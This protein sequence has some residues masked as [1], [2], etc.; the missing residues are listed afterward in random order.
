MA[1][2]RWSHKNLTRSRP[3]HTG[4]SR[5][6]PAIRRIHWTLDPH[7]T[8]KSP[9]P[10]PPPPDPIYI[11]TLAQANE[12]RNDTR[13]K[14]RASETEHI[15]R[16]THFIFSRL[17]ASRA[18]C[19]LMRPASNGNQLVTLVTR[20]LGWI[21]PRSLK[22]LCTPPPPSPARYK[23]GFLKLQHVKFTRG[24]YLRC[25]WMRET[26]CGMRVQNAGCCRHNRCVQH[27]LLCGFWASRNIYPLTNSC[28]LIRRR[29][30]VSDGIPDFMTQ[31]NKYLFSRRDTLRGYHYIVN[32]KIVFVCFCKV[33]F[34]WLKSKTSS[35]FWVRNQNFTTRFQSLE[36]L[37][38]VPI[39]FV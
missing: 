23:P 15:S 7:P 22:R 32:S 9:L 27:L 30:S 19:H 31:S 2:I 29:I 1:T 35:S 39:A 3:P 6:H 36:T 17:G 26:W 24:M 16:Q 20:H 14:R 34:Y 28:T 8:S 38:Q 18:G 37:H 21:K 5:K 11:W 25:S 12:G 33:M 10:P 13:I 4:L